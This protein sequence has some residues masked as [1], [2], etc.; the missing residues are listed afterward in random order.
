MCLL[1]AYKNKQFE[2]AIAHY[3]RAF[4]I[5]DEDISFLTNRWDALREKS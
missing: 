3:N 1:Q 5:F 4:E 2:A